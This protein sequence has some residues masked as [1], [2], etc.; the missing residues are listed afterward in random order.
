MNNG[1]HNIHE[2]EE[3]G[4]ILQG[5]GT[6]QVIC[7]VAILQCK[8]KYRTDCQGGRTE[9]KPERAHHGQSWQHQL[10]SKSENSTETFISEKISLNNFDFAYVYV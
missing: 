7:S 5:S 1:N 9:M 8:E 10:L 4:T 6:K 2:L 3:R